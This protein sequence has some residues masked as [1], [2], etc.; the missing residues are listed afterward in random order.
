M[1]EA[2]GEPIRTG[3]ARQMVEMVLV[4]VLGALEVAF[5]GWML[6]QVRRRY[7]VRRKSS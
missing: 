3:G 6:T 7:P 4:G 1:S 5:L 2:T